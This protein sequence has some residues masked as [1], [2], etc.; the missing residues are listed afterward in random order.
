MFIVINSNNDSRYGSNYEDNQVI[1]VRKG[2]MLCPLC[3]GIGNTILP[4]T[5]PHIAAARLSSTTT[6]STSSTPSSSSTSSSST[7][8]STS[9]LFSAPPSTQSFSESLGVKT[10]NLF[11]LLSTSE[12]NSVKEKSSKI[13]ELTSYV[14]SLLPDKGPELKSTTPTPMTG[15]FATDMAAASK[16]ARS[17][18]VNTSDINDATSTSTST[19]TAVDAYDKVVAGGLFHRDILSHFFPLWHPESHVLHRTSILFTPE[20]AR[21]THYTWSAAAYTLLSASRSRNWIDKSTTSSPSQSLSLLKNRRSGL[22]DLASDEKVMSLIY[23]L[24]LFLRTV[25]PTLYKYDTSLLHSGIIGP[26][27]ELLSGNNPPGDPYNNRMQVFLNSTGNASI[28]RGTVEPNHMRNALLSQP[29]AT[30]GTIAYPAPKRQA[31]IIK[32]GKA[33]L[34]PLD[35]SDAT[36]AITVNDLWPFLRTPLLEHDLHVI[37]IAFVSTATDLPSALAA[38]PLICF[39]RLAQILVEPAATGLAG[40]NSMAALALLRADIGRSKSRKKDVEECCGKGKCKEKEKFIPP[41]VIIADESSNYVAS[42]PS[43]GISWLLNQTV[44]NISSSSD[45]S[46]SRKREREANE[47]NPLDD[48]PV[49]ALVPIQIPTPP[50]SL[51]D[52]TAA[53]MHLQNT[54]LIPL[55]GQSSSQLPL[56]RSQSNSEKSSVTVRKGYDLLSCVVD[57]WIPFLEFCGSLRAILLSAMPVTVGIKDTDSCADDQAVSQL[58]LDV[59]YLVSL[60]KLQ[61]LSMPMMS[62]VTVMSP[63]SSTSSSSSSSSLEDISDTSAVLPDA[64]RAVTQLHQV[65]SSPG[66]PEIFTAWGSQAANNTCTPAVAPASSWV[67]DIESSAGRAIVAQSK[68]DANQSIQP[69]KEISEGLKGDVKETIPDTAPVTVPVPV[70][71]FIPDPVPVSASVLA[72][73]A[74]FNDVECDAYDIR[75]Q[76][77]AD[78]AIIDTIEHFEDCQFNGEGDGDDDDEDD[79]DDDDDDMLGDD[80]LDAFGEGDYGD[81]DGEGDDDEDYEDEEEYFDSEEEE[82]NNNDGEDELEGIGFFE[83]QVATFLADHPG[84]D[85]DGESPPDIS[86]MMAAVMAQLGMLPDEALP[87]GLA[88]IFE[89]LLVSKQFSLILECF[90]LHHDLTSLSC[91]YGSCISDFSCCISLL[92]HFFLYKLLL[93]STSFQFLTLC[94]LCICMCSL[95]LAEK[96]QELP[97]EVEYEVYGEC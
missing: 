82:Y 23:Q 63:S 42:P 14:M 49:P 65:L 94:L 33:L 31:T 70:T 26:L 62:P 76:N 53:L 16:A 90:D 40:T 38:L 13:S 91:P 93:I 69:V 95:E 6:F 60:L 73:A 67:P 25:D 44:C 12:I 55:G 35:T 87:P 43:Q 88:A 84:A 21:S 47:T 66:L 68:I 46:G 19:S 52:L 11:S 7:T 71:A 27:G 57:S 22:L 37:A 5:P 72:A 50:S 30:V 41:R 9:L 29:L 86:G 92:L 39:A 1:D 10:S 79:N 54:I 75:Y 45:V 61:G 15:D 78:Q 24:L 51:D 77:A 4:Y 96:P 20:L 74:L 56:S 89:S 81:D 48:N 80:A 64:L 59:I 8:S 28:L 3:K 36:P 83:Q 32:H 17:I 2:E 58:H 85:E 18:Y 34:N 97:Q